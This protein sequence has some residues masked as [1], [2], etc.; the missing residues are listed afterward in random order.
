MTAARYDLTIDQGS[1]FSLELT[2]KDSGSA[3]NLTNW[4]ARSQLRSTKESASAAASF[5]AAVTSVS[6]GKL[7]MSL[8]HHVSDDLTSGL[9]YYDL[10]LV[11]NGD[12][13]ST[14]QVSRLIQGTATL[15]REVTR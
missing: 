15:R 5:S 13:G 2:V 9:Y 6:E 8:P 10:E 3:K 1:D 12:S 4:S 14:I 11:Q 7:T